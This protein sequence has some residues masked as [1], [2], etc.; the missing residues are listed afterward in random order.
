MTL[1]QAI[2]QYFWQ[3]ILMLIITWYFGFVSGKWW[4][5]IKD[6]APPEGDNGI[7]W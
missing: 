1:E 5:R 7:W 2:H 4:E 6:E 3:L